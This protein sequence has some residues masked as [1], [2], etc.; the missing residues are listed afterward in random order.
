[1]SRRPRWSERLGWLGAALIVVLA[2]P[3]D[4]A[5]KKAASKK[6]AALVESKKH[7]TKKQR[8]GT[9][10]GSDVM[11][12]THTGDGEGGLHGAAS[13]YGSGF[14]GRRAASGERFDAAAMTAASNR[15]P[16][17]AWVAV[18]RL[19]S[20]RCVVVRVN[21]RMHA[22]HRTRIIDLSRGAAEKMKMISAGVVLVQAARLP[23]PPGDDHREACADAFV[24]AKRKAPECDDCVF[25]EFP[26]AQNAPA[27]PAPP[28]PAL[29][30]A[31]E[32]KLTAS[33][34]PPFIS[35]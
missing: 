35:P 13:F 22:R 21:D 18:R 23:K 15:F 5:L 32:G 31:E 7:A 12:A 9:P 27:V 3:A 19:D 20:D 34:L 16:L 11:A 33:Q 30:K 6:T 2:A 10:S 8:A 24:V 1:M 26:L 28:P 14:H 29:V 4:A 17:G 25:D